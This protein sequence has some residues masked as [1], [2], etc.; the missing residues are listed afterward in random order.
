VITI[1]GIGY[2]ANTYGNVIFDSNGNGTYDPGEPIKSLNTTAAGT[3]STTLTV[4]SVSPGVYWILYDFPIG[5]PIEATQIFAVGGPSTTLSPMVAAG[6]EHAVGLKSDGNVVAVGDNSYGQLNVSN[7]R[8]I[9]QIAAGSGHT[10]GLSSNGTVVAVGRNDYGQCNVTNWTGIIQVSA[11]A[12]GLN[13]VGLK[14]DYTV[15]AAGYNSSGQCAV[16]GW[17][18][19]TQVAADGYHTRWGLGPTA[20]W[21]PWEPTSTGSAMSATGQTSSRS[22]QAG[23]TQSGLSP[24]AG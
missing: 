20:T 1:T 17:S 13:T 24:T 14:A 7:W 12:G 2:A 3:F 19:I 6:T 21:S 5:L 11:S 18:N 10:V 9:V 22:P 8:G 16:G 15:V 4:P 23:L